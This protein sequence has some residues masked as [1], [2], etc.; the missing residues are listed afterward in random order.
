MS[1]WMAL[2][3]SVTALIAVV[4]SNEVLALASIATALLGLI[5][6]EAK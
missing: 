2:L 4:A 3:S 1:K 5:Y 6:K